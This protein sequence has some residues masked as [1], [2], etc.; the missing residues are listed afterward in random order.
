MEHN[1]TKCPKCFSKTKVPLEYLGKEI[2]CSKC[3]ATY[4]VSSDGKKP[5]LV[6]GS[7]TASSLPLNQDM[8]EKYIIAVVFRAI[9]IL[10]ILIGFI[11]ATYTIIQLFAI[12]SLTSKM[13]RGMNVSIKGAIGDMKGWSIAAQLSISAWGFVLCK[14][15]NWFSGL[16]VSRK[17]EE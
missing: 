10:T 17:V 1:T 4:I 9:G 16:V 5:C 15:A 2:K 3:Q 6:D 8:P 7:G 12:S 13:P 11:L 14:L